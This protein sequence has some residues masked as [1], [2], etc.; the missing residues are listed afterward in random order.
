[1]AGRR[2]LRGGALLAL[3]LVV[4]GGLLIASGSSAATGR[5]QGALSRPA[6]LRAIKGRVVGVAGTPTVHL[7]GFRDFDLGP[8]ALGTGNRSH[9]DQALAA[10]APKIKASAGSLAPGRLGRLWKV[11]S[12]STTYS[13]TFESS[14]GVY[15][16]H[17]YTQAVNYKAADG[18]LEPISDRLRR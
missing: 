16:A 3:L 5:H 11:P 6:V 17:V 4:A 15:V 2:G 8:K 13:N 18:K 9:G 7:R 12:L 14:T 10:K 1:M